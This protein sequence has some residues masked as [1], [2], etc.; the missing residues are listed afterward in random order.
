MKD[1]C[2][3]CHLGVTAAIRLTFEIAW[4]EM[5]IGLSLESRNFFRRSKRNA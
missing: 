5:L 2:L 4:R 1:F 3:F